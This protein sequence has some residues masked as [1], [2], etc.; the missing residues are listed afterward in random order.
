MQQ[1]KVQY[2]PN[3]AVTLAALGEN[4]TAKTALTAGVTLSADMLQVQGE[5]IQKD[6]RLQEYNMITLP[7]KLENG[8]YIDIS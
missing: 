6:L 2:A 8:N 3:N 4:T 5:E 7:S 1:V